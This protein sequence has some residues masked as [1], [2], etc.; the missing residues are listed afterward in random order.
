LVP[1]NCHHIFDLLHPGWCYQFIHFRIVQLREL[2]HLLEFPAVFALTN[3]GHYASSKEAF[4]I[5]LK[6]LATGHSNVM[7]AEIFR[8]SGDGMV[9]LI[10]QYLI[11]VLN[12]K[13]RR[14]L[15]D[16]VGCLQRWVPHFPEFA[17]IIKRKLNMPQFSG[18]AFH[19]CRLIGFQDCKFD[20]TCAL[21]SGPM[22]DEELADQWEEADLI[23]EL[24][25]ESTWHQSTNCPL[26]KRDNWA[27]LWTHF[28]MQEGYFCPELVVVKPPVALLQEDV[29]AALARGK[30]AV[31]FPLFSDSIFPYHLCITHKLPCLL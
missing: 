19:P 13:A 3:R 31:Y 17:K 30:A 8:F 4:I 28:R 1:A 22:M 10:Y 15:H 29:T 21:G 5:T 20:E 11:G 26:P 23:Q 27:P 2:Y 24:L 6:K 12:N 18:L 14:L 16:G 25:C 7:L 9:S